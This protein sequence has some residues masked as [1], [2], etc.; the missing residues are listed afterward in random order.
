MSNPTPQTTGSYYA[1]GAIGTGIANKLI[2]AGP[3]IH[4]VVDILVGLS[5]ILSIYFLLRNNKKKV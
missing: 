5:A 4:V 1:I 3:F 2:A